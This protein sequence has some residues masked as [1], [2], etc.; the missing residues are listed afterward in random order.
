MFPTI[1][2]RT[3]LFV[4]CFS[5]VADFWH[6]CCFSAYRCFGSLIC[7]P[8]PGDGDFMAML[9][10]LYKCKFCRTHFIRLPFSK[11]RPGDKLMAVIGWPLH[12]CPHCFCCCNRPALPFGSRKVV[13]QT[14]SGTAEISQQETDTDSDRGPVIV[15]MNQELRGLAR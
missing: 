7:G 8:P 12:Q 13:S 2:Y 10:G 1:P 4:S 14:P 15:S 6:A 11:L 3:Q 5:W 9:E